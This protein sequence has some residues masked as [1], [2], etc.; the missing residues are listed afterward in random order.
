[1][2]TRKSDFAGAWYPA[3]ES[4]CKQTIEDF[5]KDSISCPKS[6]IEIFGGIVPHAGW[7]YSGKIASNVIKC[8]KNNRTPDT[9]VIFGK[10]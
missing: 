10:H 4:D 2:E 5:S 3:N 8:M 9:I 6:E 7:Y 1:M